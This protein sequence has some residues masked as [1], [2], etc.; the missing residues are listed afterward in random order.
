MCRPCQARLL[1]LRNFLF[2][3]VELYLAFPKLAST[4]IL[5]TFPR[6]F[7]GRPEPSSQHRFRAKCLQFAFPSQIAKESIDDFSQKDQIR[8][9]NTFRVLPLAWIGK[10][11]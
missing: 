6:A 10:G 3:G 9:P 7:T 2:L 8:K 11:T 1:G 4:P 5:S